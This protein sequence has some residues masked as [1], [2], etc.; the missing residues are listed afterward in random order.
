MKIS[1]MLLIMEAL[2]ILGGVFENAVSRAAGGRGRA[3]FFLLA[4]FLLSGFALRP[5]DDVTIGASAVLAAV[6]TGVNTFTVR[7]NRLS[8][9]LVFPAALTLGALTAPLASL[10]TEAS[11]YAAGLIAA[12]CGLL[13]GER[14]GTAAAAL[15]PVTACA[16][17]FMLKL[18][19]NAGAAFELT[20]YCL[21]VQLAGFLA[22][23]AAPAV[24]IALVRTAVRKPSAV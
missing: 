14:T 7:E 5:H 21:S 13:L 22:V 19:G 4:L 15:A 2:L 20:E 17:C 11:A 16:L 3:V 8:A 23:F 9:M 24:K 18:P 6:W 10:G 12:P 1:G